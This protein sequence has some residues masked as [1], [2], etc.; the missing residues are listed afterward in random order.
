MEAVA[1]SGTVLAASSKALDLYLAT[2]NVVGQ[3]RVRKQMA[4]ILDGQW[5]VAQGIDP[6]Q[7][8]GVLLGGFSGTGK[9]MTARKMCSHLGLPYAETDATRYAEVGYKGL[10]LP[11]MFIPL[12]R[13]AARMID[14][15]NPEAAPDG[16]QTVPAWA[17]K[18]TKD[19]RGDV[20]QR[21][22]I[23]EVVKRAEC[24]VIVLDEFDKWMQRTNHFSGQKD[25]AIQSEFL[26]MIEGSHE[27]VSATDDLEVGVT[28][29]T[30]KVLI[31]CAG[32]F[33]S[34]YPIVRARLAQ[35]TEIKAQHMDD[36]FWNSIIPGDFERFGLLPE[37]AGR[38]ARNIFTSPLQQ[39]HMKQILTWPGGILDYYR[40]RYEGCGARWEVDDAGA[41]WMVQ[42]AMH[43]KTGARALDHIAHKMLGGE[44]LFQAATSESPVAVRLEPN[45]P[46]AR[47]VPA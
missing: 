44:V 19:P 42:E 18:T 45:W 23:D 3:K 40:G 25:T 37:L 20:F 21:D 46:T 7:P 9:T 17:P 36:N 41:N 29:A 28:F 31:I 35:D 13:E 14:E 39:H 33:I 1:E 8:S 5:R 43:H 4:V 34:L 11:Q 12:L 38:L 32:A 24:G 30:H 2:E 16:D 10:Q 27:W 26:K 22:D 6:G 47:L 15:E